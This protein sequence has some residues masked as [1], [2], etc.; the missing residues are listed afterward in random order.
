MRMVGEVMTSP[1]GDAGA[2]Q[3]YLL[4]HSDRELER[5][6][7]QARL[8]DPITR[9]FLR[10]AGLACGMRVLDVGSG[11]GDVALLAAELVGATGAVVSVDRVPAALAEARKRV[12]ALSLHNVTFREGDPTELTF[13]Q[14]F[15]AV[16]GRYVLM[17]QRDPTMLLRKLAAH[18]RAGGVVVFHE[19]DWAAASSFPPAP[20]YDQCSR[21][22]FE[23]VRSSGADPRMGLKL[24]STF[25]GAGLPSPLMRL[26]SVIGS[27]NSSD[28]VDF[29]ADRVGM[30]VDVVAEVTRTLLPEIE[31]SG[32]ATAAEVNIDTLA[33][34]MHDEIA[35]SGSVIVG[36]SEIGAWSRV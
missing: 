2:N 33:T 26:E 20:T 23:S 6:K 10:D 16:I 15:D 17:F 9:Q 31:R 30:L 32:V 3:P 12:N 11:A 4:G 1:L 29:R 18:V 34:R 7:L 25:V 22:I 36:R 8:I 13:Q 14:P 35:A 5:L 19:G 21:W 28:R 27:V 24:H